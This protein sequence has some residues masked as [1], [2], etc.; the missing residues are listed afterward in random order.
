[1]DDVANSPS[2]KLYLEKIDVSINKL[3]TFID[4]VLDHS[5][6]S[7]KELKPER[8]ELKPFLDEVLDNLKYADKFNRIK[9]HLNLNEPTVATDHFLLKVIVSN[10]I[11]NAIKYQKRYTDHLPEVSITTQKKADKF[12]VVI[13]DNGEGIAPQ[14]QSR[15]F[16]MFY[17]GSQQSKG[18][19]LGLY[20][21]R[22]AA[23]RMKGDI[24]FESEYGKGTTFTLILPA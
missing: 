4:E 14:N 9:F 8:I 23:H 13:A 17:R 6:A 24:T 10:L 20:I 2:A 12:S 18:S 21:A 19:G 22:E 11:S 15:V 3:E 16:E 5:R 1:M 7:R